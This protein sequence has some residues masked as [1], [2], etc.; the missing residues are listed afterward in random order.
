VVSGGAPERERKNGTRGKTRGGLQRRN[1]VKID[2]E[3]H[4]A[5]ALKLDVWR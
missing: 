2:D 4:G 3:V 5:P 1:L